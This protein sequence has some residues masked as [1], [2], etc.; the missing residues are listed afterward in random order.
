MKKNK[1]F[2][3]ALTLALSL[4]AGAAQADRTL[5][6]AHG[7]PPGSDT[8]KATASLSA[9]IDELTGGKIKIEAYPMSLLN[10]L[11]TPDGIRDGMAD[12][13]WSVPAYAPAL[14]PRTNMLAELNMQ[15][16]FAGRTSNLN[17]AYAGA[18]G[19][20]IMLHCADCRAEYTKHNQVYTGFTAST[21]YGLQC[22]K[23][24]TT[25]EDI[26]GK[27]LRVAG[28]QWARWATALG[29]TSVSLPLNEIF[30]GLSQ[31]VIDCV[32]TAIP[33][34]TNMGL[35]DVIKAIEP[36]IPGG[37]FASNAMANVN[38][39]VWKGLSA[40]ERE[41]M[42]KAVNAYAADV[43][44]RYEA[45]DRA[46]VETAKAAGIE[47]TRADEGLMEFSREFA[48]KEAK[49]VIGKAYAEKFGIENAQQMIDDFLPILEK[50]MGLTANINSAEEIEKLYWSEVYEKLD[51]ASYGLN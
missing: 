11:E 6:Y 28:A 46:A 40:E 42:F 14:F 48:T 17:M 43:T 12:M 34:L 9:R 45:S 7:F 30:E 35:V 23:P 3:A 21:N 2:A 8:D 16:L 32:V 36:S 37:T 51:R 18:M 31:G 4:G 24:V 33:E 50:W 25:L 44:W 47:I 29:A 49:E 13:G 27:R 20:Y 39:D 19:E 38:L 22:V 10:F 26:K 1:T 41:A 5:S 15:T